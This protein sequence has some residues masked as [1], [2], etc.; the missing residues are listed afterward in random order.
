MINFFHNSYIE[1][2]LKKTQALG[3]RVRM[4]IAKFYN[5]S[6]YKK[7]YL[8][9]IKIMSDEQFVQYL[10]G[11]KNVKDNDGYGEIKLD[12][13]LIKKI[14]NVSNEIISV[15]QK[16]NSYKGF[17]DNYLSDE[18]LIKN[19]KIFLEFITNS[20][21]LSAASNYLG[22]IP[23]LNSIK[24]LKTE[25]QNKNK[26]YFS[27]QLYHLDQSDKPLFKIIFLISDTYEENGP[28]TFVKKK[29]TDK[30][31]KKIKSGILKSDLVRDETIEKYLERE[32]VVKIIGKSGTCYYV[33]SSNCFHRGSRGNTKERRIIIMSYVSPARTDFRGFKDYKKIFN[34]KSD[35]FRSW[36]FDFKKV[37]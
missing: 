6:L 13:D 1:Y 5:Y 22:F 36:I 4:P 21:I 37:I 18:L 16:S 14:K 9:R 23:V 28:F 17:M 31:Q 34:L 20:C 29:A 10:K 19:K 27:S 25:V 15:G 2:F 30:I 32:D 26:K 12:E 11:F 7:E 35:D 24:I 8:S 33:D 3:T